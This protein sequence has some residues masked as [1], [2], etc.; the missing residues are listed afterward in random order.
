MTTKIRAAVFWA[1]L[2][3]YFASF[4]LVAVRETV[5]DK[6]SRG[7]EC[8]FLSVVLTPGALT[9]LFVPRTGH[10]NVTHNRLESLAV[11]GSGLINPAFLLYA[12]AS[13]FRPK[14]R[15]VV[16][17]RFLV[18]VLIPLCWIVFHYEEYRPRA[19][20]F[21]WISGML[22]VLF[23]GAILNGPASAHRK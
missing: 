2:A 8:A 13:P 18:P 1:G 5:L 12:I 10:G 3:F 15:S 11:L 17:C 20:H 7:Y 14:D 6:S 19:G 21:V 4:F 23:S 16:I 22:L 9:D